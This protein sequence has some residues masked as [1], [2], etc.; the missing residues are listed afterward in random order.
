MN[1]GQADV[2]VAAGGLRKTFEAPGGG[3]L[4]AVDGVSLQVRQGELTA[5][6]G[7]DGAGKTTLLRMIAGLLKPDGGTLRVLGIDVTQDP[8]AVQDRISYMP[9]RFGLYEDL[10]VQGEPRALR[11]SARCT[12]RGA[13]QTLCAH[14][15]NDR[16]GPI[17]VTPG[18]KVVGR[19]ETSW[20]S[21]ARWYVRRLCCCWTSPA[22][23]S[24]RCLG[25]SCGRSCSNWSR[26]NGSV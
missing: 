6:V 7:P 22:S 13:P 25:V 26:T 10:T 23:A 24:I 12:A 20:A 3:P 11:R 4:Y 8:Q 17:H 1:R 21:P 14:A 9:Q 5:L 16:H 2:S 15:G 19:H 18:R